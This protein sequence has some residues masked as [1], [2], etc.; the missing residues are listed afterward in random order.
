MEEHIQPQ[1]KEVYDIRRNSPPAQTKAYGLGFRAVGWLLGWIKTD[2]A[3]IWRKAPRYRV[4]PNQAE[5]STVISIQKDQ[6]KRQIPGVRE[7][8]RN[9]EERFQRMVS[10]RV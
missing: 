7:L 5:W 2:Q 4:Q 6:V 10:C 9:Q 8:D 3:R 1:R